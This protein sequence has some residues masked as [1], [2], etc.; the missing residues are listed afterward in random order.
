MQL[1]IW[2]KN[3]QKPYS[4]A[5]FRDINH[6][7]LDSPLPLILLSSGLREL[8]SLKNMTYYPRPDRHAHMGWQTSPVPGIF[9]S[10]SFNGL[11]LT[12]VVLP[13]LYL[14]NSTNF[15]DTISPHL[16]TRVLPTF[17]IPWK[18]PF[19]YNKVSYFDMKNV[20]CILSW[21]KI[22]IALFLVLVANT[23]LFNF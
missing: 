17:L 10:K 7:H 8:F 12:L 4:P 23:F 14:Q 6:I 2:K 15:W 20:K 22:L 16:W 9:S 11:L 19:Q 3:K 18:C 13:H 21:L 5:L 1:T